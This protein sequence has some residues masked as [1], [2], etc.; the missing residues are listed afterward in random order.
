MTVALAGL[1]VLLVED[2]AIVALMAEDMLSDMGCDVVGVAGTVERGL[3]IVNAPEFSV[4]GAILDV[5]LGGEKV[6][7][8][9]EAL[10]VRGVPFIFATGYGVAGILPQYAQVPALAKPYSRDDLQSA[11][12]AALPP[13]TKS[14]DR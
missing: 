12:V 10:A 1:R 3:A 8:I 4:D 2:E 14:A 11:L 9:A 5:N 13:A 7:P 6:Y